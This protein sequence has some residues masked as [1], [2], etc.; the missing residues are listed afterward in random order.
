[1][2][3]QTDLYL[4]AA[5]AAA[6]ATVT[7]ANTTA[8]VSVYTAPADDAV[9]KGLSCVSNDTAAVNLRI[10]LDIGGTVYQIA[11]VNI[12]IASGT[13]GSAN[14]IDLLN[15]SAL[16]FL[17]VDRNGK[18]ILP[19]PGG[20]ILKVAALATMTSGKTLTVVALPETY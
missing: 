14:A 18:R 20:A 10:G 1:M 9:I 2:A 4:T 6:G 17:P 5:F 11:T 7:S 19:L 3:K 12:P 8:W 16:P 13:N 15:A